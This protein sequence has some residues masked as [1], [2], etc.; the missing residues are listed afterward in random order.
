[1]NP[2]ERRH[3]DGWQRFLD[4]LSTKG[5]NLLMLFCCFIILLGMM[6]HVLHHGD[7]G[8]IS[9]VIIATF[10]GFAGALMATLSGKDSHAQALQQSGGEGATN[11]RVTPPS[12]GSASQASVVVREVS[13]EEGK[14]P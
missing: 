1:M 8:N 7:S 10:S 2:V 6:F 13:P 3:M 5:G 11:V 12:D 14:K 4:S 9:T